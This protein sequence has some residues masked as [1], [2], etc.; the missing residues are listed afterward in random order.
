MGREERVEESAVGVIRDSIDMFVGVN[1]IS[2]RMWAFT[3]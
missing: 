1:T 2:S 3:A